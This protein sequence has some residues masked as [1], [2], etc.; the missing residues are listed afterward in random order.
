VRLLL[1]EDDTKSPR[2]IVGI[3]WLGM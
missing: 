1:S 3:Q 2:E